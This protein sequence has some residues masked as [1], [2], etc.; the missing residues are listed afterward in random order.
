MSLCSPSLCVFSTS[1]SCLILIDTH[2]SFHPLHYLLDDSSILCLSLLVSFLY[3]CD[4]QLCQSFHLQLKLEIKLQMVLN[5]WGEQ[6]SLI[7]LGEDSFLKESQRK[8]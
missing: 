3:Y 6:L 2:F 1:L 7:F 5:S 4:Y 8:K